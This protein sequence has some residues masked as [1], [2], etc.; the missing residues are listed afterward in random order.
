MRTFVTDFPVDRLRRDLGQAQDQLEE[1][2]SQAAEVYSE[3]QQTQQDLRQL[4]VWW[5]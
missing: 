5:S 3:L 4:K 2:S 1:K